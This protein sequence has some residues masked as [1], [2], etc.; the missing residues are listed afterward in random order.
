MTSRQE[1]LVG[2]KSSKESNSAKR[3]RKTYQF[4]HLKTNR[5]LTVNLIAFSGATPTICG[6]NPAKI[7]YC[8]KEAAKSQ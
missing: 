6:S 1:K 2:Q 5:E 3:F 8:I 4:F 7:K